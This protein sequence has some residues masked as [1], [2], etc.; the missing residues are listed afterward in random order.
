MVVAPSATIEHRFDTTFPT[1]PWDVRVVDSDDRLG[2]GVHGSSE[3]VRAVSQSIAE[4]AL[5]GF[6]VQGAVS[7]GDVYDGRVD[8]TGGSGAIVDIGPTEVYLPYDNAHRRISE[9]ESVEVQVSDPAAPWADRRSEVATQ[10]RVDGGIVEL[11]KDDG[12]HQ[13]NVSDAERETEL[14]RLIEFIDPEIPEGWSVHWHGAAFGASADRREQALEAAVQQAESLATVTP[15]ESSPLATWWVRFGR[16]CRFTLDD[17]R[18][19]ILTTLAGHHRIKAGGDHGGAAVDFVENLGG[20]R[21]PTEFP[22]EALIETF[23]PR[24]GSQLRLAH[25]KPDG[26]CVTLGPGTVAE[27]DGETIILE[28]EMTT[29]GQYDGIGT[30]REPGDIARTELREGRWWYRTIYRGQDGEFKGAYVNICTPIELF[31][32]VAQ[33]VDLYV[34]VTKHPTGQVDRVDEAE[35]AA[36][37][38][39]GLISEPVA[40]RTRSVAAAI[41]DVLS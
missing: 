2:V 10:R 39:E 32:S 33:Y 9:G 30:E 37:V 16:S 18:E 24:E 5:D 15:E 20:N 21:L 17:F 35:L 1:E 29:A 22:F 25:T 41:E 27:R 11:V 28:R 26:T 36:A 13:A 8:R 14:L 4:V 3:A 40:E 31:P 12:N 23:G 6:A 38:E 19:D 7:I 34:D